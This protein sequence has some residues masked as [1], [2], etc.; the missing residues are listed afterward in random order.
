MKH[1]LALLAF[2]LLAV[3]AAAA[4]VRA[5]DRKAEAQEHNARGVQLLEAGKLQQALEAFEKAF[6]LDPSEDYILNI[7]IVYANMESFQKA[8]DYCD[9]F[10]AHRV[11][12]EVRE[13][14]LAFKAE[15]E[16]KLRFARGRIDVVTE[17]AG[18]F[19]SID[20]KES[21]ELFSAPFQRW[22][23]PGA[24][25]LYFELEGYEPTARNVD[26]TLGATTTVTV[27]M[28]PL[29]THALLT[30]DASTPKARVFAGERFLGLTPL[31][32][33]RIDPG[34]VA[35]RVEATDR[36]PHRETLTLAIGQE[37][38]VFATLA[39][40]PRAVEPPVAEPSPPPAEDEGSGAMEIGGW[41]S[42]GVGFACLAG[43]GGLHGVAAQRAEDVHA[44]DR[45][46]TQAAI[47]SEY[48]TI[49]GDVDAKMAGSY[50]LYAV[51]GAAVVTGAVLLILDATGPASDGGASVTPVAFPGGA[52]VSALVTF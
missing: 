32:D 2:T 42:L 15:L 38:S 19:V 6:E 46:Q 29:P 50:A 24:H 8:V 18:V 14:V 23:S 36:V 52:G 13:R 37:V 12:P 26:V 22:L 49:S 20:R 41:V 16:G 44:I 28:S 34:T 30:V 9:R 51:G 47:R 40:V 7:A 33:F 35:L 4:P 1:L 11:A 5:D 25:R 45:N 48:N 3:A 17:P 39:P 10:L 43:A 31:K 27:K 21:E